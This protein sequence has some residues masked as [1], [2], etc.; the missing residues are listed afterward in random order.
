MLTNI[1]CTYCTFVLP[2]I[3]WFLSWPVTDFH[4]STRIKLR[5]C[6]Y[7]IRFADYRVMRRHMT[8]VCASLQQKQP[9]FDW[10]IH[11][12]SVSFRESY[13]TSF[14]T[15]WRFF[16]LIM[17][18]PPIYSYGITNQE[19]HGNT[20]TAEHRHTIRILNRLSPWNISHTWNR[21]GAFYKFCRRCNSYVSCLAI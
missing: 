17:W 14:S 4:P 3:R 16:S 11:L 18:F 15:E 19:N 2:R 12:A 8:I 20:V 21:S 1:N 6:I 5:R 7:S 9:L 13:Q 10:M